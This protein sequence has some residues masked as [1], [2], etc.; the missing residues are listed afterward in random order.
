MSE[1]WVVLIEAEGDPA[2]EA[3]DAHAIAR[4]LQALHC[5][6]EGGALHCPERYALQVTVAGASPTAVLRDVVSRWTTA[7]RHLELPAWKLVR[8]EV[9]TV[10]EL[11]RQLDSASGD[12]G[13]EAPLQPVGDAARAHDTGDELLRHALSDALT[14]LP[15]R[16]ALIHRLGVVLRGGG[17]EG[18][19]GVVVVDLDGFAGVNE[20]VGGTDADR[21]LIALAERLAGTL[22]PEDEVARFGGDEFAVVLEDT[23]E[24]AALAVAER[25]VAAIGVPIKLADQE[26]V[27]YGR[28]MARPPERGRQFATGPLQDRLAHLVLMQEAAFAANGADG[29]ASAARTIMTQLCAHTGCAVGRLS[30]RPDGPDATPSV[31]VWHTANGGDEGALRTAAEELLSDRSSELGERVLATGRPVWITDVTPGADLGGESSP[32][33]GTFA[34][35]FAFPVI[36]GTHVAAVVELFS[37]TPIEATS[38]F[39]DVLVAVGMQLGRV[40]EREAAATTRRR[41]EERLHE[42]MAGVGRWEFH[43][44]TGDIR[45]SE[46]MFTLFGVEPDDSLDLEATIQRVHPADRARARRLFSRTESGELMAEELRVVLPNGHTR[47]YRCRGW[48]IRHESGAIEAITGTIEDITER[49]LA[50]QVTLRPAPR[51]SNARPAT[52]EGWWERDLATGR[53]T[54]SD[55]TRRLWGRKSDA[56]RT[57]EE[58]LASVHPDDRSR[59]V[60]EAT[61][62]RQTG[63]PVCTIFRA[64]VADG[65]QRW[66]R[67][68][69]QLLHDYDGTPVKIFGT[70][71]DITDD[72]TADDA[73]TVAHIYNPTVA[74]TGNGVPAI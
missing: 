1:K 60:E 3:I 9:F 53:L 21:L 33:D 39:L 68:V 15:G 38:S 43:P 29:L 59:V 24:Q 13:Q 42:S 66:F 44:R 54:W 19:T 41:L 18:A 50:E 69:A 26:V 48:A 34:S 64:I 57:T 73:R 35:A 31:L 14:G 4:L 27:L 22:R 5:G 30:V 36:V 2:G 10:A 12:E 23:T 67:S 61:R 63:E 20:V 71:R 17:D 6:S 55:E 70:V 51:R 47:W 25:L 46:G 16:E 28:G 74:G 62:A 65:R 58:F 56:P 40:V 11:E 37:R 52:G 45:W 8:A 72:N 32:P 7:V 49:K